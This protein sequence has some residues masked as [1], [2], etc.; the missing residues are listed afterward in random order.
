MWK[1]KKKKTRKRAPPIAILNPHWILEP[2]GR[3]P[4]MVDLH[5]WGAWLEHSPDKRILKKEDI[6]PGI[7]VSTIFLAFDHSFGVGLPVLWET[8]VFGGE[9]DGEMERYSSY[10]D[11]VKGHAVM[12]TKVKKSVGIDLETG[13]KISLYEKIMAKKKK[14]EKKG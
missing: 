10:A 9:F 8:M 13:K 12:A 2:D 14:K 7:Q 5:T 4:K 3:T 1:R 11:A 6:A